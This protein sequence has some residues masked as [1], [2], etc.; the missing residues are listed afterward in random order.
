MSDTVVDKSQWLN[1]EIN[2]QPVQAPPGSTVMDVATAAKLY[3]PHFCY[4]K[5]LSLA[6]S[7]RMCLVQVEKIP[8]PVP[9]CAT[10]VSEG[11]KVWTRSETALAAQRAVMQFLLINHPLDCPICDQGGECQLQDIAVGYGKGTS[12]FGEIKRVVPGKYLGPL[13]SAAE[14]SRCIQC[15]RCV[16]FADEIG[17]AMELGMVSRGDRAEIVPFVGN[18]YD[19]EIS[20]NVIDL[21]PVGALTSKPFR[22]QARSWELSRRRSIA[23]HDALGSN[24]AV[25]VKRGK[26]MRIT[27]LVNEA[28]NECWLSDRDRFSYEALNGDAR[29]LKPLVNK[30]GRLIETEWQEALPLA[31]DRLRNIVEREGADAIGA[32]LSPHATTEEAGLFVRMLRTLGCKNIDSRLRQRD[33]AHEEKNTGIPWLGMP[34][35]AMD[36][37]ETMLVIGSFLRADHP[38]LAVRFRQAAKRGAAV[39]NLHAQQA[40]WRL[41]VRAEMVVPPSQMAEALAQIIVAA[42][43]R[44]K[45]HAEPLPEMLRGVE[46][47]PQA[48][49]I[50]EGLL[51]DTGNKA[52]FIGSLA[53]HHEDASRLRMLAQLLARMVG[54]TVAVLPDAANSVGVRAMNALPVDGGLNVRTMFEQPR[55]AYV[56][57]NTEPED[58]GQGAVAEKAL[59]DAD[60][61]LSFSSFRPPENTQILPDI[62]L[63]ITPFTETSGTF[64]NMEGRAQSFSA[65]V[66]PQ[67]EARPGWQALVALARLLGQEVDE[68]SPEAVRGALLPDEDAVC[69]QLSN[70]VSLERFL[71]VHADKERAASVMER[72]SAVPPY[73]TDP[74]VRRAPSLQKTSWAQTPTVRIRTQD[75]ASLKIKGGGRVRCCNAQQDAQACT[76]VL[77]VAI[78]DTLAP[79]TVRIDVAHATTRALAGSAGAITLEIVHD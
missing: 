36:Q 62:V 51:A 59:A 79:G 74:L 7:C 1:L 22:Y 54:A 68:D 60:F 67:G 2:G 42:H 71:P 3:I 41:P 14:M 39:Y 23:P 30:N 26:V 64:I 61:V 21:C 13:V 78:D 37:L 66:P 6:A 32:L 45:A 73:A 53:Q 19:S 16:R 46:P 15:T 4:H 72:I 69:Q 18:T 27:P 50:A 48:Q 31:A 17:G 55:K 38:L 52:I 58:L 63:P 56:L 77:S 76:D 29:L 75:A 20:G 49:E 40:D 10:R 43:A 65:A 28:I 8:K 57:F 25:H 47:S 35:A 24:I 5:K 70:A 9:A 12:P 44:H 34:I 33:F 11:M